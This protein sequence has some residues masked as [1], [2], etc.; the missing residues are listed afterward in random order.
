MGAAPGTISQGDAFAVNSGAAR[1]AP[2]PRTSCVAVISPL[3]H[4]ESEDQ[5]AFAIYG[6]HKGVSEFALDERC[7]TPS[8]NGGLLKRG[9]NQ[10][11]SKSFFG[12]S[13]R[14]YLKG[15]LHAVSSAIAAA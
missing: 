4:F 12:H 2:S 3:T 14:L 7:H 6:C 13:T 11:L 1:G 10:S 9:I 8:N 15:F 5:P